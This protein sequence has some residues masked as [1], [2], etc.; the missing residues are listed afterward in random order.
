MR[1]ISKIF[2]F[3]TVLYAIMIFYLSSVS[4]LNIPRPWLVEL[5]RFF[6]QIQNSDYL[7]LLS[8][9]YP[10][11][12]QQDKM[13]HT[14]L[15]FGFGFLL[16]LT[17]KSVG[18]SVIAA[19]ILS[20]IVG[21]LYGASD[22]IHQMFVPGRTADIMDLAADVTGILLALT[23]FIIFYIFIFIFL[24]LLGPKMIRIIKKS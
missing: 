7:F 11:L 9:L 14:I 20:I 17:L 5:Y 24:Q 4:D 2:L 12:N 1:G 16:F 21:I 6:R 15:Y 18:K 23:L 19:L 8:P 13:L 22:E 10:I 3:L